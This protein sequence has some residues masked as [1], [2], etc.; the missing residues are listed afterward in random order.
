MPATLHLQLL[1]V[2][3][4]LAGDR[5]V[6]ALDSPRLQS[7]LARLALHA[8]VPQ[9]RR[10]LAFLYWP[11]STEQQAR[12]NLRRLVYEL[13]LALP[14]ADRYLDLDGPSL[15]WRAEAPYTLDVA[16][17]RATATRADTL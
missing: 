14:D 5:P 12:A 13:R 6:T 3:R 1:G 10:Q 17:F 15:G 8:G 7:L 4:V 2:F 11:D 9:A 16:Q